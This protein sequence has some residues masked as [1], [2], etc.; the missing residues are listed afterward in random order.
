MF[1]AKP[2][3]EFV[4]A[5]QIAH[6][7]VKE[8]QSVGDHSPID[9]IATT[10][11][12]FSAGTG[13]AQIHS[14]IAD[15][16]TNEDGDDAEKS[17]VGE[18]T[19]DAEMHPNPYAKSESGVSAQH[20]SVAAALAD[21][22]GGSDTDTSRADMADQSKDSKGHARTSSVKKPTSFKPV[23]VTKSFLAKSLAT[24]PVARVGDKG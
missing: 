9:D 19:D 12:H 6:D 20:E 21:A 23:S 14:Y 1:A 4:M 15:I 22:S 10:S 16:E 8:A 17:L 18:S 2:D 3:S 5:E 13:Q 11:N 24:A 7:V